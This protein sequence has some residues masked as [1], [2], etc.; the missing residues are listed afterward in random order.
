MA[1][2]TASRY[3]PTIKVFY[4]RLLDAGKPKKL[5]LTACMRKLLTIFN[6]MLRNGEYWRGSA[7]E[8]EEPDSRDR[9]DDDH[10]DFSR[11]IGHKSRG[12]IADR[13]RESARE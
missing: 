3:N 9:P 13:C 10:P 6:A 12:G 1:A 5:A 8:Q 11:T 2:L 7:P 4:D